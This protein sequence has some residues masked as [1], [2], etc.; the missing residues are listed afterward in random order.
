MGVTYLYSSSRGNLLSVQ[1]NPVNAQTDVQTQT[2]LAF[3]TIYLNPSLSLSFSGGPQYFDAVQ[4]SSSRVTS[5][6]PSTKAAIGWQR[7]HTNFVASYS[8]TVSGSTGLS[9]AFD[10]NNANASARWQLART[11][12]AGLAA[13]YTSNKNATPSFSSSDPGGHS[14]SGTVSA[15]HAIGAR[16][17]TEFGYAR[18]H[19]SYSGVAAISSNPD[20]DR[21]YISVSYRFERPLGR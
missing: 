13:G 6:T 12:I 21:A 3:Y 5:W 4:T 8:R 18:L 1:A 16:L 14:L 20:S 9:G 15:Q 17:T 19:Q 11:W 2:T 10:S 7:S